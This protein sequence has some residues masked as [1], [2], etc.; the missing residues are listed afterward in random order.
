VQTQ[1]SLKL[2]I[3]NHVLSRQG[4]SLDLEL[5]IFFDKIGLEYGKNNSIFANCKMPEFF[6]T[7]PLSRA[8][9]HPDFQVT[10]CLQNVS[11]NIKFDGKWKHKTS[12][13]C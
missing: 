4:K 6:I 1:D 7:S 3:P 5:V 12:N 9:K 2:F 11:T 13:F 8:E 10:S